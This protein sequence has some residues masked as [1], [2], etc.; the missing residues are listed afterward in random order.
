MSA[1]EASRLLEPVG[2]AARHEQEAARR[3]DRGASRRLQ[4]WCGHAGHHLEKPVAALAVPG[5]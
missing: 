5:R 2:A 1:T 3:L 4:S